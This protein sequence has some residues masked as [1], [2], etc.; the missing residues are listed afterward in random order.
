[1]LLYVAAVVGSVDG[2]GVVIVAVVAAVGGGDGDG[3]G[4]VVGGRFCLC[5]W[6]CA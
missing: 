3:G 2:A 6:L 1:M 5:C 4:A